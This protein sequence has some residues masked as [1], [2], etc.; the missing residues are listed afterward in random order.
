MQHKKESTLKEPGAEEDLLTGIPEPVES[1]AGTESLGA[2][3]GVL[4]NA[5]T[6]GKKVVVGGV[7]EKGGEAGPNA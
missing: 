7:V 5:F 4:E 1:K 2:K 6:V 3:G